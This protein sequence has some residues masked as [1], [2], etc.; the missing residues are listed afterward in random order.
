MVGGE[1]EGVLVV[2][3][4]ARAVEGAANRAVIEALAA[5]LEVRPRDVTLESGLHSRQKLLRV[6]GEVGEIEERLARLRRPD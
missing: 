1:R 3:V 6:L 5:A 2:R 4:R